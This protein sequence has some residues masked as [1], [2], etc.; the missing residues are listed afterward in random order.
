M[1][2]R[3]RGSD[4]DEVFFKVSIIDVIPS[5]IMI[6]FTE[7][8]PKLP[9][10]DGVVASHGARETSSNSSCHDKLKDPVPL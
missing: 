5:I 7:I 1:D 6:S 10:I 2:S 4:I 9:E 8:G 3:L